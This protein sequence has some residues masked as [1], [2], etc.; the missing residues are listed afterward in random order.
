MDEESEMPA[1]SPSQSAA[2]AEP[3]RADRETLAE[4]LRQAEA[5]LQQSEARRRE[6][7][8]LFRRT[9]E[10]V[11]MGMIHLGLDG[12]FLRVNDRYCEMVGYGREEL[13]ARGFTDITHPDDLPTDMVDGRFPVRPEVEVIRLEK[14]YIHRHGH[15]VWANVTSTLVRGDDGELYAQA[16]VE[17][18]TV[19]KHA[20]RVLRDS[21]RRKA[22]VLDCSHEAIVTFDTRGHIVEFNAVAERIFGRKRGEVTGRCVDEMLVPEPRRAHFWETMDDLVAERGSSLDSP[23]EEL[24]VRADGRV[25]PVE[26]VVAKLDLEAQPLFAASLRDLTERYDAETAL[27]ESEARAQA[28]INH[29][30]GGVVMADEGY[31]I[32][33]VNTAAARMFGYRQDEIIGQHLCAILPEFGEGAGDLSLSEVE[34]QVMGG[35][36]EW[37]GQRKDGSRFP[38]ELSLCTFFSG[39]H[40]YVAGNLRDLSELREVE[41]V[42][43]D[44]ISTVNHELRTPLTS[45]RGALTLIASG[46][47]GEIPADAAEM[48]CLA[49]RNCVRLIALVNDILD[50]ERLERGQLEMI[51]TPVA[52]A[53]LMTRSREVIAGIAEAAGVAIEL[54]PIPDE[55]LGDLDRLV[56]VLVNLLSNAIKFSP[57]GSTVTV[58]ALAVQ[59]TIEIRVKDHGR[60]VAAAHRELIFERFHQVE[61]SDARDK[62][63]TGLGL[64]IAKSIVK[65]LGGRIGLESEEGVGSTFWLRLPAVVA[66]L[67]ELTGGLHNR[68]ENR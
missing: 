47:L 29:M 34:P 5:A 37:Q 68:M 31:I 45:I 53:E 4:R 9:F 41:R 63:G 59:E 43:L 19:R 54:R 12:R 20:E 44:L 2:D 25:F 32:R 50:L 28:I 60:G 62:G 24:A 48:V 3:P 57:A 22:A 67:G 65:Q 18:I 21:E 15:V 51:R 56:Q 11:G 66:P 1:S 8:E 26:I 42:K 46:L 64:A 49:E 52:V 6:A 17:D 61:T 7:E 13:L 33:S 16:L 39:G 14:R 27:L 30:L 40:R 23:F 55:L 36:S 58:S 10:Q 38:F 35:I